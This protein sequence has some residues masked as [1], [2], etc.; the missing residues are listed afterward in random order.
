MTNSLLLEDA[1][2]S[3]DILVL[4]ASSAQDT[5]DF[6]ISDLSAGNSRLGLKI[7]KYFESLTPFNVRASQFSVV[8]RTGGETFCRN[9]RGR[10]V[11]I[12]VG[13]EAD[14]LEGGWRGEGHLGQALHHGQTQGHTATLGQ[15]RAGLGGVWQLA[16]VLS[17]YEGQSFPGKTQSQA[18]LEDESSAW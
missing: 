11:T 10:V 8:S 4:P 17:F 1:D 13:R 14:S 7:S 9:S 3:S 12:H 5:L 6:T 18:E 16:L 15:P 2:L